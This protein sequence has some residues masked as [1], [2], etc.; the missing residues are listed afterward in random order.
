MPARAETGGLP[1]RQAI[2]LLSTGFLTV[3][4]AD[5]RNPIPSERRR[6]PDPATEFEVQRLTEPS[7]NSY[8]PPN[9][10][11]AVARRGNLLIYASDRS[12][13]LQA[14]AMDLQ[15]FASTQLSEAETLRKETLTLTPDE[16]WV[17]YADGDSLWTVQT[18]G[19]RARRVYSAPAGW[20]L[21]YTLAVTPDGPAALVAETGER[22]QALRMVP[23]GKGSPSTVFE[24]P[25]PI[26]ALQPRP[27]RAAVLY[28]G[29]EDSLWLAELPAGRQIRLKT[30]GPAG[31]ARWHP[32][33]RSLL[34]L[35]LP[36]A[37][38]E[39]SSLRELTPDTGEDKLIGQT[40][41]FHE[42]T[43]NGDASVFLGASHSVAAPYMLLLLRVARR[44]LTLCEHRNS[45]A[46][47][48]EP[49]FAPDSQR[50]YFVSDRHGK[51]AIYTMVVDR[52]VEKTDT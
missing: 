34:Y 9:T 45:G 51:P 32:E 17:C 31:P 6:Y 15:S 33:G 7:H 50:I 42:F 24:G 36:Q 40:S 18:N 27:R 46:A 30:A 38:G 52:L 43:M 44:E 29:A 11:K 21:G 23:L 4:G 20:H 16:R 28:R 13:S 2:S 5:V 1:R 10:G 22:G 25:G 8:L 12:G 19:N 49:T 48:V 39:T 47:R 3:L 41:Q 37:A 35:K 26:E 14:Y